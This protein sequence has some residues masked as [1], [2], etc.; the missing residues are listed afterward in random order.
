MDISLYVLNIGIIKGTFCNQK[1]RCLIDKFLNRIMVL[2]SGVC[3][4][5]HAIF[6]RALKI[7]S[8]AFPNAQ[9]VIKRYDQYMK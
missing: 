6:Q 2:A 5:R 3:F 8:L 4:Q 1:K 9:N 7:F